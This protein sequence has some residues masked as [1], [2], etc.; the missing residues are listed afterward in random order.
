MAALPSTPKLVVIT[1]P[2]GARFSV[3]EPY[4]SQFT[5]LVTD[6]ANAGYPI[7]GN[8][9]GGYNNRYIA[10]TDTPSE[11]AYG[12]AIDVNWTDNPHGSS[13]YTIPGDL[14]RTLAAKYGMT[15]GGDWSGS[16]VDPMHFEIAQ[17]QKPSLGAVV[18][19]SA[20]ASGDQ[21]DTSGTPAAATAS[22][23]APAAAT[24]ASGQTITP[25]MWA[26]LS[27]SSAQSSLADALFRAARTM[28]TNK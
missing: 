2:G 11:H 17:N 10:G 21:W 27:N 28:G 16:S 1:A 26:A 13:K 19:S 20:P 7:A 22:T 12:R 24:P 9:S 6:L 23:A 8:Q 18:T 25:Q 14:A 15:W 4:Q 3:A 5:G